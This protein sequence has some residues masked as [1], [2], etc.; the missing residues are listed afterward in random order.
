MSFV[1][2]PARRTTPHELASPQQQGCLIRDKGPGKKTLLF[3]PCRLPTV[4]SPLHLSRRPAR[5][6]LAK[7]LRMSSGPLH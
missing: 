4:A 2:L 7:S 6:P 5:R 3:A 1:C